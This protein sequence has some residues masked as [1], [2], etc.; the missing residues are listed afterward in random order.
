MQGTPPYVRLANDIA[1]QFT[2]LPMEEAAAEVAKHIRRFWEPRMRTQ[3]L[4]HVVAGGHGLHPIAT[5]A[6][7]ILQKQTVH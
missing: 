4:A 5:A 7:Q 2:H 6:A 1:V 3:L